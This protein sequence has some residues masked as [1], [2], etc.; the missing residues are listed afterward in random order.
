MFAV[1]FCFAFAAKIAVFVVYARGL[2][3]KSRGH[4]KKKRSKFAY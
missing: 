4:M 3:K 1:F 2:D